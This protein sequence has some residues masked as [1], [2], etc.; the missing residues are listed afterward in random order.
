MYCCFTTLSYFCFGGK[1]YIDTYIYMYVNTF[2]ISYG[3]CF[4]RLL[5]LIIILVHYFLKCQTNSMQAF[6]VAY[7]RLSADLHFEGVGIKIRMGSGLK[8]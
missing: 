6:L 5:L 4:Y 2:H 3:Y 1:T 7:N 8:M